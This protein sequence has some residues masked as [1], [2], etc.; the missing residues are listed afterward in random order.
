LN[1]VPL[2]LPSLLL[3]TLSLATVL[4]QEEVATDFNDLGKLLLG[5]FALAVAVAVALTFVRL[6]LRDRKAPTSEF[7]SIRSVEHQD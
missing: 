6:R 7:I 1:A 4:I 3:N 5:G 2:T